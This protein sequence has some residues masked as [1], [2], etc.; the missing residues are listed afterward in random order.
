MFQNLAAVDP[1]TLKN[2][3]LGVTGGSALLA[4]LMMK[5]ISS[6][7]GKAVMA[8]AFIALALLGYSQRE[9]ITSCVEQV[10]SQTSMTVPTEISCQFFG[11]DISVSVPRP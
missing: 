9:E 8:V 5:V 7:I 10:T 4:V 3:A 2:I 6:I 1:E 11:Q